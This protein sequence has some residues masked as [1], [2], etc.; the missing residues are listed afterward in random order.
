MDRTNR[1]RNVI[2]YGV[3]ESQ[4]KSAEKRKESDFK[5]VK[6]TLNS[7][8]ELSDD[9]IVSIFRL[10]KFEADKKR[11]IKIILDNPQTALNLLKNK[12]VNKT[13]F[14]ISSDMTVLER[15]ELKNLR[16]ELETLNKD[17]IVKTIKFVNGHPKIVDIAHKKSSDFK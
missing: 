15:N 13:D 17:E 16:T 9:C 5:L 6:D 10:G 2:M 3:T 4:Y 11:P 1:K 7:I 14:N 12:R 8:C